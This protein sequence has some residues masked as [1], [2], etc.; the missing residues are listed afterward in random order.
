MFLSAVLGSLSV[1]RPNSIGLPFTLLFGSGLSC[2]YFTFE[3]YAISIFDIPP[4]YSSPGALS[5]TT[6]A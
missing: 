6:L 4:S 3:T 2:Y 1:L 5:E